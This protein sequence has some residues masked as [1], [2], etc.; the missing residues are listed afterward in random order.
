MLLLGGV[1]IGLGIL[2]DGTYALISAWAAERIRGSR[3]FAKIRRSV[4]GAVY[5]VLGVTAAASG[6]RSNT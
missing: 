6:S 4:T 3:S 2:S 5:V 1:F